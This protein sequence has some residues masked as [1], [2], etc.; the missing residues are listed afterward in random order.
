MLTALFINEAKLLIFVSELILGMKEKYRSFYSQNTFIISALVVG[1]I[2]F[3]KIIAS[4]TGN[5]FLG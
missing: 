3:S 4:I 1:F 2:I 5:Q